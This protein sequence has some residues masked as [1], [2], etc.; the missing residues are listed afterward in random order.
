MQRVFHY[1]ISADHTGKTIRSYL[2]SRGYSKQCLSFL[3]NHKGCVFINEHES[4]LITR[5]KTDD[6]LKVIFIDD[7]NDSIIPSCIPLN[8]VYEDEDILVINKPPGLPIHPSRANYD[9][10]L[11]NAVAFYLKDDHFVFRCINRLDRDTTVLTIIAKN[12]YAASVLNQ[13]MIDRT[14]KRTYLAVIEGNI[15]SERGT[16]D[17]PISRSEKSMLRYVDPINGEKAMTHFIKKDYFTGNNVSLIELSLDTGKT[18][19]IRV[20]MKYIG[21]PLVGDRLYNPDSALL[22]RQAL[23]AMRLE[24]D[25]PVTKRHLSFQAEIPADIKSILE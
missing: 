22:S 9:R 14:I 20:H 10:S 15:L 3:A 6:F 5:I 23:H 7:V 2:K 1:L 25:H 24:F 16:I 12:L 13:Q 19:Q 17:A 18:H 8:I 11:A 4:A 21:H